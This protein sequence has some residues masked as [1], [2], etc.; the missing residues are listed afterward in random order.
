MPRQCYT[1]VLLKAAL[2]LWQSVLLAVPVLRACVCVG[3][4]T[5]ACIPA[6]HMQPCYWVNLQMGKQQLC[7]S[8]WDKDRQVSRRVG[9]GSSGQAAGTPRPRTCWQQRLLITS[10][11]NYLLFFSSLRKEGSY[12]CSP[13]CPSIQVS[14]TSA[15][16][17]SPTFTER[18]R[19][20]KLLIIAKVS[21]NWVGNKPKLVLLMRN[22]SY[23][24]LNF[25]SLSQQGISICH[26]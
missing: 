13:F 12:N 3:V 24:E 1:W 4:H 5:H 20:Q 17:A 11:D 23:W 6:M 7:P 26:Q 8:A 21:I 16:W 18:L 10:L 15:Q 19:F 22:R 2:C 25:S 9:L 14:L